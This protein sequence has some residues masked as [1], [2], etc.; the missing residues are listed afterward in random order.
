V[1]YRKNDFDLDPRTNTYVAEAS[2]LGLR[3][4][5][6]PHSVELDLSTPAVAG[7]Q[8][9][10]DFFATDRDATGE[11]VYGWRYRGPAGSPGLLIVND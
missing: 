10:Y 2:R 11:D 8:L 1:Y 3:P 9:M 6:R 5:Q 4:G 7:D